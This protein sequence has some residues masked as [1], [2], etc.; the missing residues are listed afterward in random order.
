MT[1]EKCNVC[2][3]FKKLRKKN[4]SKI[5]KNEFPCPLDSPSLGRNT[6]SFL[7][8]MAAYY[9]SEPTETDKKIMQNFIVGLSR[10]YPCLECAVNFQS[11]L[12]EY[13]TKLDSNLALSEWF[14]NMHN[15]VNERLNKPKFDCSR[16]LERWRYGS[17]E[18]CFK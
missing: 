14:C 15:L 4:Q 1:Q 11:D 13:P 9:P 7:H 12:E 10:F 5:L 18:D 17:S 8:T 6:W 2:S 3:D 16:V